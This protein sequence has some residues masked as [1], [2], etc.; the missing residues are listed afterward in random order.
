MRDF[1]RCE[2]IRSILNATFGH[3]VCYVRDF[4]CD[5]RAWTNYARYRIICRIRPPLRIRTP[6]NIRPFPDELEVVANFLRPWPYIN[7]PYLIGQFLV[8]RRVLTSGFR[9]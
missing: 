3:R 2:T 4:V 5:F 9:S 8:V 7:K 6:L 1:G